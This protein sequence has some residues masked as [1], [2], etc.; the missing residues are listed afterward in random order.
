MVN[1]IFPNIFEIKIPLPH[2][3]LG[4]LNS[5]LIRSK[6]R[7]L[8]IDTGLNF[9]QSYK[10]LVKGLSE[11]EVKPE[12]LHEILLTHF[13]VD[14]VGLIPRIKA[15]SKE[16]RLLIHSTEFTLSKIIVEDEYYLRGIADFLGSNGA[17]S[18]IAT[19]LHRF[20]PAFFT[21]QAYVELAGSATPVA[22]GQEISIGD[23]SFQVLWTPGH[24]PGHIC[25]YE[26]TMKILFSGDHLLPS[27]TSHVS[28]YIEDMDPLND[29]LAS[30]TKIEKLDVD[31]VLPAHENKFSHYRERI[32][33]LREHHKHRLIEIKNHLKTESLTAYSLASRIPWDVNYGSWEEFPPFQKYLALGE[34]L[35]HLKVLEQRCSVK[36][37][38]TK[39]L[40]LFTCTPG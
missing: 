10:S 7:N 26:P 5:Y 24:S 19:K 38:K 35:A 13:H 15:A 31:E 36:R 22:D 30:L 14:H 6:G 29:Y 2:S 8:L 20:H 4:H 40:T 16:A 11:A 23:Y 32:T 37:A 33:Q 18:S 9:S 12:Q 39:G 1:Q 25:L 27:I 17:P 21:P 28:Q 3:P 34:T